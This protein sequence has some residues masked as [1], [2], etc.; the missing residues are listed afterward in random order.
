MNSMLWSLALSCLLA[1]PVEK[2]GEATTHLYVRTSPTGAEIVLDGKSLGKSPGVFPV[3]P[4]A[5]PHRL[6]IELDGHLAEDQEITIRNGRVTRIELTLKPRPKASTE[7][8]DDPLASKLLSDAG[9]ATR[10]VGKKVS[11]FPRA[12]D[13]S[14]PESAWAAYHAA[15]TRM[16]ANAVVDLSWVKNDQQGLEQFWTKVGRKNMAAY[17]KAQLSAEIVAVLVYREK[18][19]KV[20]SRLEFPPRIWL[21]PPYSSMTFGLIDGKWKN[22]GEDLCWSLGAATADFARKRDVLWQ[23]YQKVAE[24]LTKNESATAPSADQSETRRQ[25][26]LR[27][28]VDEKSLT[29]Q[30][31]ETTWE[32]LPELLKRTANRGATVLEIARASSDLTVDKWD[33]ARANAGRLAQELGFEYLSEIGVHALGS[34]GSPSQT[35]PE[36]PTRANRR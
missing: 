1:P 17:N 22:L 34:K 23:H 29:F 2:S 35:V 9:I 31:R 6:V 12:V 25:H 19:A 4:D 11:D 28:V 21:N 8:S 3:E 10:K 7:Q 15:R 20:V 32:E 13:L 18:L 36:K 27:L 16:D 33:Q 26:F 14:T 24:E 30:G 5:R